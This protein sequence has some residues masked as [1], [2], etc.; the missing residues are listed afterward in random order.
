MAGWRDRAWV[1]LAGMAA[2]M[3]PLYVIKTG[4]HEAWLQ[5]VKFTLL[6][7]LYGGLLGT[8]RDVVA[9]GPRRP[10]LPPTRRLRTSGRYSYGIYVLHPFLMSLFHADWAN[11]PARPAR[12]DGR[13][14]RPLGDHHRALV[15]RGD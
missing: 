8:G 12:R 13:D 4:S 15:R 2:V 9:R 14:R 11:S 1:A 6:A 3:G 7:F 5:A 10:L